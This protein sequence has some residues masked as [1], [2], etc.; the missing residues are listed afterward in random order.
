MDPLFQLPVTPAPKLR[1]QDPEPYLDGWSVHGPEVY[2]PRW[3]SAS[4]RL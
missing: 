2:V 1:P 3:R 4:Y